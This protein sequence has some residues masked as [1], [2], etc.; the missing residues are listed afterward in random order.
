MPIHDSVTGLLYSHSALK[1]WLNHEFNRSERYGSPF[2]VVRLDLPE[3]A[4]MDQ[5]ARRIAFSAIAKVIKENIRQTDLCAR[6]GK[7]RL[8][9]LMTS[10]G[11]QEAVML[12]ERLSA[13]LQGL[14]FVDKQLREFSP[15]CQ[16][17]FIEYQKDKVALE[18]MQAFL[19]G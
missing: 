7:S 4:Q 3:L 15:S 6:V 2:T 11:R 13:R 8:Y 18:Q 14:K 1:E 5:S 19:A 10:T 16:A 17:D 12:S 9:I